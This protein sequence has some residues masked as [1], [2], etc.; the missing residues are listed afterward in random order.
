MSHNEPD[1]E[2]RGANIRLTIENIISASHDAL[3]E[4]FDN[5][6]KRGIN[7]DDV[8]TALRYLEHDQLLEAYAEWADIDIREDD[9]TTLSPVVPD[10]ADAPSYTALADQLEA[11]RD[12]ASPS[13]STPALDRFLQHAR[14]EVPL[15][16][17]IAAGGGLSYTKADIVPPTPHTTSAVTAL[18]VEGLKTQREG[19]AWEPY[20]DVDDSTDSTLDGHF[21]LEALAAYVVK[22]LQV[23]A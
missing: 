19:G 10:P 8:V 7:D 9:N 23:Q 17:A 14:G 5:L 11:V 13:L 15:E 16:Q 22:G 12:A 6:K 2:D 4:R 3:F 20:V 21:D 1:I 18:L